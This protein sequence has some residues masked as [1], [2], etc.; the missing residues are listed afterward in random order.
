METTHCIQMGRVTIHHIASVSR[1]RGEIDVVH[2]GVMVSG[3]SPG[4]ILIRPLSMVGTTQKERDL[5]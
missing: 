5:E 3:V 2:S 1:R 4:W